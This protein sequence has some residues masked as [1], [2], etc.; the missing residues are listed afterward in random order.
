[1]SSNDIASNVTSPQPG[2]LGRI[3]R[4][5]FFNLENALDDWFL[6]ALVRLSFAAI[7]LPYY[8]NS[9]LTKLGEGALGFL[10]PSAGAFAQILPP[11]AEQ[12][13]YDTSAIPYVPWHL[14]VIAGTISE[15]VLPVLLIVGL[16]TRWAALGMI[17][18][19][20]VQTI[21]DI[22]F[23]GAAPGGL[24]NLKP[25]ELLDQRWLWILP[26]LFLVVKGP[27]SL[28]IDRVIGGPK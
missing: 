18:F 28:S 1:M 17:G 6:G 20:V 21:V 23:H 8:I 16:F 13:S 3:H 7:L 24:F 11:I 14:V 15:F 4:G 2:L 26:L 9:A 27:G 22:L 12:Y 19:I 25:D 5:I 10:A